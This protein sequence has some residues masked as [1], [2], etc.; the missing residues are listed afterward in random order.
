MIIPEDRFYE[1]PTIGIVTSITFTLI[2][3]FMIFTVFRSTSQY[4]RYSRNDKKKNYVENMIFNGNLYE[5][6]VPDF[7]ASDGNNVFIRISQPFR[8]GRRWFISID[9]ENLSEESVRIRV[10]PA[11]FEWSR[12]SIVAVPEYESVYVDSGKSFSMVQAA[13][14]FSRTKPEVKVEMIDET[15]FHHILTVEKV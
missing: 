9:F 3:A 7:I 6:F 12:H 10:M 5:N 11:I 8:S 13:Q 2:F 15:G 4:I 1:N 14:R